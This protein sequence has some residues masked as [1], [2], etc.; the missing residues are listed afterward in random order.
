MFTATPMM[1]SSIKD[2]RIVGT[3]VID[4]SAEMTI[5]DTIQRNLG[6][7]ATVSDQDTIATELTVV[8]KGTTRI[9]VVNLEGGNRRVVVMRKVIERDGIG[10]EAGTGV[11]IGA[12][13]GATL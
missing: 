2:R 10:V 5:R 4:L 1:T 8:V 6:R 11:G 13:I 7:P 3:V 9:A 12:E